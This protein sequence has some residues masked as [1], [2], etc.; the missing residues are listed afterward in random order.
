MKLHIHTN[1]T[2]M[3]DIYSWLRV[4][5]YYRLPLEVYTNFVKSDNTETYIR[6]SGNY[7]HK[8]NAYLKKIV[9][10][11]IDVGYER[12]ENYGLAYFEVKV[13]EV[14]SLYFFMQFDEHNDDLDVL[15]AGI[16][17]VSYY[18]AEVEFFLDAGYISSIV[19]GLWD[20][21]EVGELGNICKRQPYT[22]FRIDEIYTEFG[23]ELDSLYYDVDYRRSG[24]FT[25]GCTWIGSDEFG[26]KILSNYNFY[27]AGRLKFK[28]IGSFKFALIDLYFD[29]YPKYLTLIDNIPVILYAGITG[30]T[31]E[32]AIS[33]IE[34]GAFVE[35]DDNCRYQ[36]LA[37]FED[38]GIRFYD[39]TLIKVKDWEDMDEC[40]ADI[41]VQFVSLDGTDILTKTS[42][43]ELHEF[44][45]GDK[46][47]I[48]K[49]KEILAST[50]KNDYK[51]DWHLSE[52][53]I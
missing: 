27:E 50:K 25:L 31:M 11:S 22:F 34:Q 17:E 12:I 7:R 24:R 10:K 29:K 35:G 37:D 26:G 42:L 44:A 14:K 30:D 41:L 48:V 45:A 6:H 3:Q 33:K 21:M 39:G 28:N 36:V 19:H 23:D 4:G 2:A 47:N 18:T 53:E 32:V 40:E 38:I 15:M 51:F 8:V 1:L 52:V 13:G 46:E 43:K 49:H 5:D 16:E 9:K 20:E